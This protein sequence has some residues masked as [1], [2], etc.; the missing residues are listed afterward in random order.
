MPE[1]TSH[2]LE[3]VFNDGRVVGPGTVLRRGDLGL[4]VI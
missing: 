2:M 3:W 4:F 1:A